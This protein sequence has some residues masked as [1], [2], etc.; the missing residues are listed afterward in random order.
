[1]MIFTGNVPTDAKVS[2]PEAKGRRGRVA[3][4]KSEGIKEASSPCG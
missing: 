3:G 1:M 2:I 4:E